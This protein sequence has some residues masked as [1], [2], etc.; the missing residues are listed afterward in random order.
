MTEVQLPHGRGYHWSDER[1]ARAYDATLA[2]VERAR[3]ADLDN[4]LRGPVQPDLT[5]I[6]ANSLARPGRLISDAQRELGE[7]LEY[8]DAQIAKLP[9]DDPEDQ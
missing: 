1:R 2:A 4:Q 5:G 8:L 3:E 9:E 6:E 7:T